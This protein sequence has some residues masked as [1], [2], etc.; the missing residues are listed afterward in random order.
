MKYTILDRNIDIGDFEKKSDDDLVICRCEEITK[1]EIRKAIHMGLYTMNEI[2]RFL[3]P[4][5][6][7]CQGLTCSRNI[8]ALLAEELHINPT[9]IEE[10]TS[11]PP[12]R[13]VAAW[14]YGEERESE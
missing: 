10:S 3:R 6:G 2:K 14:V 8:K 11:R 7:L 13:P 9:Q 4:G 1:G 5:M 12:A